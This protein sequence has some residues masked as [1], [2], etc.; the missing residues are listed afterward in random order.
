MKKNGV[1]VLATEI[2][3]AVRAVARV[4]TPSPERRFHKH[5]EYLS[6]H[7]YA[8]ELRSVWKQFRQRFIE[9]RLSERFD[10]AALLLS[11]TAWFA[12]QWSG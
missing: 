2:H 7:L 8:S 1:S 9:M 11:T 10:L 12:S 5:D 3:Q 6:Y 4:P